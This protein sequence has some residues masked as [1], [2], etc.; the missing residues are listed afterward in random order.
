MTIHPTTRQF[1]ELPGSALVPV[2]VTAD[3]LG[4]SVA[5][6]WRMAA[7]GKLTARRVG[8]RNTRFSVAEIRHLLG[9]R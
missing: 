9:Q 4:V 1:D 8:Q 7:A 6:I 3:V 2:Q 5:T